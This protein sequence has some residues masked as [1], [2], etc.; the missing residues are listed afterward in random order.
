VKRKSLPLEKIKKKLKS[1]E[2]RLAFLVPQLDGVM[3]GELKEAL[4]EIREAESL[5]EPGCNCESID[6]TAVLFVDDEEIIRRI[7]EKILKREGF[8]VLLASDGSEALGVYEQNQDRIKCVVLDLV[9]PR[10][11]GMQAFRLLRK[12]SPD[13]GIVLT[14]GYCEE[15][16][17]NRF[18]ALKLQGFL[19]KPF[20]ALTLIE[21]V[22]KAIAFTE[23]NTKK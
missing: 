5:L 2:R 17:K 12:T 22:A 14:T 19:R 9:M 16:I 11:D 23:E 18:G 15:E 4:S 20:S 13:L 21:T 3:A 10:M 7:G 1:A 6:S 8:S